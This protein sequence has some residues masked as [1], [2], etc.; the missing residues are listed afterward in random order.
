MALLAPVV[1]VDSM[2]VGLLVGLYMK[3]MHGP[4]K[5]EGLEIVRLGYK[6][7]N[8]VGAF[9]LRPVLKTVFGC[10]WSRDWQNWF[11]PDEGSQER[12]EGLCRG[13]EKLIGEQLKVS[14]Q[15][16]IKGLL[17]LRDR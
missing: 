11:A 7:G 2:F 17:P 14:E 15:E 1:F 9:L 5:N 10:V 4:L 6:V 16:L 13:L 8:G 12:A 3:M